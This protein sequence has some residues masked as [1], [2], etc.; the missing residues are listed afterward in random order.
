MRSNS[1]TFLA[2]APDAVDGAHHHIRPRTSVGRW[3]DRRASWSGSGSIKSSNRAR[4]PDVAAAPP[5]PVWMRPLGVGFRSAACRPHAARG[6]ARGRGPTRPW[7][8]ADAAAP[9]STCTTIQGHPR[10]PARC[11]G[12]REAL[13]RDPGARASISPVA[14][15]HGT[16]AAP[17][18]RKYHGKTCGYYRYFPSPGSPGAISRWH[19]A[20]Y[21]P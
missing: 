19:V 5:A 3:F 20:G 11:T 6:R 8:H 16:P 14:M 9:G 1:A 13:R 10:P 18:R 15:D 2:D 12:N 21:P 4:S 17:S 7:L